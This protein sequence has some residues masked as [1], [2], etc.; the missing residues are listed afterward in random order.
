MSWAGVG[1]LWFLCFLMHSLRFGCGDSRLTD[2]D[3]MEILC[4]IASL[5]I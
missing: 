4:I 5:H 1:V 3:G 2:R